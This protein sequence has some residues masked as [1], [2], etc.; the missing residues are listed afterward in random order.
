MDHSALPESA[1]LKVV[2]LGD[3]G[4]RPMVQQRGTG[5]EPFPARSYLRGLGDV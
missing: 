5:S 4:E 1:E 2:V 3:K